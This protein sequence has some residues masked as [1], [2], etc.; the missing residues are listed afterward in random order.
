MPIE[1][2]QYNSLRSHT[3]AHLFDAIRHG[4]LRPG[5][6]IVEG[7]LAQQLGVSKTTLREAL[8]ELN[9]Q[10]MV[11]KYE[12]RG[13]FVTKLT[14]QDLQDG[15]AVRLQLEP[16]AAAQ[17][18]QRMDA[19]HMA[20][21][22]DLLDR[23]QRAGERGDLV[24]VSKI[25][26]EF[27]ELI[28]KAAGNPLLEKT[29]KLICFPM[30]AFELIQLHAA[31]TYNFAN[32]LEEHRVLLAALKKGGPAHARDT[33]RAML[34]VFRDQDIGNLLALEQIRAPRAVKAGSRRSG[35]DIWKSLTG[36]QDRVHED[37][38]RL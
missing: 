30:W 32:M 19:K 12:H 15:Y 3:S 16:Y 5:E 17:A 20:Q 14:P 9:Y 25:D 35:D 37:G 4:E 38:S 33:F 24:A 11:T 23:I 21:L 31:P 2:V 6:R 26:A 22:S 18:Q 27:H 13:T 1:A 7:K 29:L 8:Q 10:G 28:W 34:E 36:K